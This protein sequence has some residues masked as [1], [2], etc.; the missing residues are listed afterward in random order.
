MGRWRRFFKRPLHGTQPDDGQC[1]GGAAHHGIELVQAIGDVS[2]A[3]HL[4]TETACQRLATLQRA[5]GNGHAFGVFGCEVGGGQF[6][7]FPRTDEQH[8]DVFQVFKQLPARRTAAAVM[9]MECAPISV[10]VRTC[11]ATANERWNSWCKVVPNAP[12]S[13]AARTASLS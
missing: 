3:Q 10:D 8:A 5:V 12:A 9:L 4:G 11:L 1:A 13:S 2:Q 6:D 7:H